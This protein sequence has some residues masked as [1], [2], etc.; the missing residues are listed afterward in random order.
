MSYRYLE[1]LARKRLP[2]FVARPSKVRALRRL[3]A[4]GHVEVSFYPPEPCA[5]QF[6]EVRSLTPAGWSAIR[7]SDSPTPQ[8]QP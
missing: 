2:I 8:G 4:T 5:G 7:G 6:G 1:T 3:A